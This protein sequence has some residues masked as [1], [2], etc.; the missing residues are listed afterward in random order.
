[1]HLL[2]PHREKHTHADLGTVNAILGTNVKHQ[3]IHTYKKVQD[4]KFTLELS[5]HHVS[6]VGK[7]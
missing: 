4:G 7:K 6:S 3:A 2:Q 1:L 5:K